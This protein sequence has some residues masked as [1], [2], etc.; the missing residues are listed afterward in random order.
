MT[1][2]ELIEKLQQ[3][4]PESSVIAGTKVLEGA[5]YP[6]ATHVQFFDGTV[7]IVTA[8]AEPEREN[9]FDQVVYAP[10]RGFVSERSQYA[11][12]KPNDN[13]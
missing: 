4:P 2:Q 8:L 6:E 13:P 5:A 11:V 1:V 10:I 12:M 9:V 3:Y 7:K